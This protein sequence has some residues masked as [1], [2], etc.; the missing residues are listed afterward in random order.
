M[1]KELETPGKC[2][3]GEFFKLMVDNVNQQC[4]DGFTK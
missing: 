1:V 4:Y 3:P 2:S